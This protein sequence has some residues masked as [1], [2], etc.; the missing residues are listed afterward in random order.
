LVIAE[1]GRGWVGSRRSGYTQIIGEG[2]LAKFSWKFVSGIWQPQRSGWFF[3]LQIQ[4]L[5]IFIPKLVI[6]R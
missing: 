3:G 5:N 2:A 6:E 4:P 1:G